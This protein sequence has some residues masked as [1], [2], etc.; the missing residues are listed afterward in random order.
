MRSFKRGG[1]TDGDFWTWW[2][3]GRARVAA[4]IDSGGFDERLVEEITRAVRTIHPAIAWEL[5][6]GR[7]AAHAFC[8]SAEGNAVVRQAAL[9]WLESAPPADATWEYHASKQASPTLRVVEIGGRPVDLAAMRAVA[10]WDGVRRRVDVRL[11]HAAFAAVPEVV[12]QQLAFI[13]LDSLLGEDDVERWIGQI[14]LLEAP[15]GGRTPDELKAEIDRRRNEPG[16]DETWVVGSLAGPGAQPVIVLANAALKRVDHPFHDHHVTVA[17]V[18]EGERGLPDDAR[19]A[20]LNAEEDDLT[21]R[22]DGAAILA[23]RTTEPGVRT[24][25]FVTQDPEGMKLAIDAWA[26]TVPDEPPRRIKV[27]F[28]EDAGWEFQRDLGV[29]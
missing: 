26:A 1:S 11:W 16:G 5:A 17:N 25:H 19:A 24:L 27:N 7:G 4:A 28:E 15:A 8:V 18:F 3:T 20:V 21:A 12:R 14:D 13:F 10:S 29:R 22:L 23:G 2:A 6:P 9:R